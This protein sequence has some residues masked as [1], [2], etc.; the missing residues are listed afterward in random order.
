MLVLSCCGSFDSCFVSGTRHKKIIPV[1]VEECDISDIPEILRHL[2]LCDYTRTGLHDWFWEKLYLSLKVPLGPTCREDKLCNILALRN[3]ACENYFLSISNK[4]GL[5]DQQD[6]TAGSTTTLPHT[7]S[8]TAASSTQPYTVVPFTSSIQDDRS[9]YENIDN[10]T[11]SEICGSTFSQPLS[12]QGFNEPSSSSN[13]DLETNH[14]I[15]RR[16]GSPRPQ[17]PPVGNRAPK[18]S[19]HAYLPKKR[20]SSPPGKTDTEPD[21]KA[22]HSVGPETTW[23]N[24]YRQ[25]PKTPVENE[26]KD[27]YKDF[28]WL[29]KFEQCG[30]IID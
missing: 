24:E 15:Y 13:T 26:D 23:D 11:A 20:S 7:L 29:W 25:P 5:Q 27:E 10:D 19:E 6:K 28:A 12:S 16:S 2:T 8:H 9:R 4:I 30:F 18:T 3:K 22:R 1:L 17:L 21:N 14:V